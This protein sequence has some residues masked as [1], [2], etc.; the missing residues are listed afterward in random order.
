M[1][2]KQH[3]AGNTEVDNRRNVLRG[4]VKKN[5]NVDRNFID[6]VF[7]TCEGCSFQSFD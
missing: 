6:M 4:Q 7:K 3:T 2:E 5:G 1:L